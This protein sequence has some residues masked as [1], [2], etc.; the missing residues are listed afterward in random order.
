M[1][2]PSRAPRDT[3]TYHA[4]S[5]PES[6]RSQILRSWSG[7][8]RGRLAVCILLLL[9]PLTI[10]PTIFATP[11]PAA[12]R[13][14]GPWA[15]NAS[16][17]RTLSSTVQ[18]W[19]NGTG[20]SDHSLLIPAHPPRTYKFSSP[21]SGSNY[22]FVGAESFAASALSNLGIQGT[23]E[24]VTTQ[25]TG[26]L[27]FW[28]ADEM[29]SNTIWGQV[30]YYICNGATPVAFY[31]IW[32]SGSVSVTGTTSVSTGSHQFSMFLQ[33]GTTW[34]YALD[35]ATFGT[36]NM[37]SSISSA[38]QAV[39]ALSEESYVS[40][41]WNPPQVQFTQIQVLKA[42]VW[43]S[44]ATGFEPYACTNSSYSCW[45]AQG[46]LQSS[47][48]PP[49][50][51]AVGGSTPVI[52]GGTTLWNVATSTTTTTSSSTSS[53]VSTTSSVSS[54]STSSSTT[55]SS[56]SGGTLQITL[57]ITPSTNTRKSTEYFTVQMRDQQGNPV[58]GASVSLTITKPNGKSNAFT[59]STDSAGQ[60]AFQYKLS[61]AALLGTYTVSASASASG[62]ASA[63]ATGT[64]TVT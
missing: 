11:Q 44:V 60:A 20:N 53:S 38:T 17:S 35:G 54:S 51:L 4:W 10:A 52:L 39:E 34:A 41:P 63:K 6:S 42:G 50:G 13:S 59:A 40:G 49:N 56:Q 58:V 19:P 28:V 23:I 25:V 33:S 9:I 3:S 45:G 31:Q 7:T 29:S 46:N 61:A 26:C 15:S 16:S 57:T 64:F 55:S 43:S 37:G 8:K 21:S 62:Y 24:V 30:G 36:Y 27:S 18:V 12:Q 1:K 5:F 22:Y 32:K 47:A 2:S 48:V 14:N